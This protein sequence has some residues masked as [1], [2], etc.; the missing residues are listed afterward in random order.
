VGGADIGLQVAL[1]KP[2]DAI[3]WSVDISVSAG[4]TFDY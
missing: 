3:A 4:M 1:S 2:V